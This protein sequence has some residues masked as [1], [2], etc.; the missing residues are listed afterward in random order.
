MSYSWAIYFLIITSTFHSI[1]SSYHSV[2][3]F[4]QVFY[5]SF[6][7]SSLM[8]PKLCFRLCD[9]P[10]IYLQKT[11]CRCSGG[12]LMHNKQNDTQCRI[13]CA[14]SAQFCGGSTTYSA[15]AEHGFYT[16][17]GHLLDYQIQY[18]SCEKWSENY[19]HNSFSVQLDNT[20]HKSSLNKLERCAAACLDQ[21]TTTKALAF[22]NDNNQCSCIK[23]QKWKMFHQTFEYLSSVPNTSCNRYCNNTFAHSDAQHQFQC[24]S[25]TDPSIWAIYDLRSACPSDFT[26]VTEIKKCMYI[27]KT[28]WFTCPPP[29][30]SYVYDGSIKWNIFLKVIEKL[31]LKNL[32]VVIEFH[33][34]FVINPSLKCQ[35]TSSSSSSISSAYSRHSYLNSYRWNVNNRYILENGCLREYI[36]SSFANRLCISE[37]IN[38]YSS[39]YDDGNSSIYISDMEPQTKYCPSSWFDLNG[40]CYRISEERKTI[41]D[42]RISCINISE[43]I[44]NTNDQS[45]LASYDEN[46]FDEDQL[47]NF[48]K[49][50]IVQYT[51]QWQT[52]LGFFLLDTL[53]ESEKKHNNLFLDP[54]NNKA[55]THVLGFY[56]E[57]LTPIEFNAHNSFINKNEFQMMN[58]I[59]NNNLSITDDSCII[60]TRTI[61]EEEE[62]PLLKN[63]PMNNCSQARHVLCETKTLIVRDFQQGCFRKPIILDLPALISN[64]LTYELCVSVCKEL[65]T[66]IA[67]I[68]INKCYCL[69]GYISKSFSLATDLRKYQQTSCGNPCS[70]NKNEQCG[71][72]DTIIVFHIIDSRR[73]YSD[74]RTPA[75]PYPDF[76]YDSCIYLNSFDNTSTTYKFKLTNRTDL[77]P[78]HCLELCTKYKQKYALINSNTCFCTN[79]QLKDEKSKSEIL[80][81]KH[82]SLQCSANYFY[83]CGHKLNSTLYSVYIMQP[84]CRHGFEVA[85]NDQQCVYSHL[86]TRKKSFSAAQSYCNS[87]G[88]KIAKINDALEIQDILPESILNTRLLKLFLM[89]T[90]L[91]SLNNTRYFWVDRTLDI[92]DNNT[93]S[94]RLLDKCSQT[95]DNIDGNCIVV[96]HE[97][98][99]TENETNYEFCVSESDQCSSISAMPVCVDQHIELN[100]T[101]TIDDNSFNISSDYSCGDNSDYHLV[102]DYCYKISIHEA[103]WNDSKLE[104]QRDNAMLFVP[105]KSITLQVIKTLFLF[106]HRNSYSSSGFAHVG[107]IYDNQNRTV[108]EY[109]TTNKNSLSFVPDSNLVYDLCEKTFHER[110]SILMSSNLSAYERNE[111][112][113]KQIGCA[114]IDLLSNVVPI[115]RCDEIPCNRTATVICQKLPTL[116]TDVIFVKREKIETQMK[117]DLI[118]L[119]TGQSPVSEYSSSVGRDFAPI[120]IVLALLSILTFVGCMT[121]FRNHRVFNNIRRRHNTD[122]V[123]TQL[124]SPNEF[125]LN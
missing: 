70:G 105:E 79:I 107:V 110:Y 112:K 21:D 113:N 48:P 86:S 3:C 90:R 32:S 87:I 30:K 124:A 28:S 58:P 18:S 84:K 6:F 29:S 77:H 62:K 27:Y 14:K 93:I 45:H 119:S 5:D 22:N 106:L 54:L 44:V 53:S 57:D 46:D 19:T 85:E 65:Q 61:A 9:T 41:Q 95:P 20:I 47:N 97:K 17:H 115:I 96:R 68:H 125:G 111:I 40:R 78:R 10:I 51:S 92:S 118:Y 108:I 56:Y 104:C 123:Y 24:G 55:I 67:I 50:D 52:R 80:A 12:G 15:Y 73:I 83:T 26:Y 69:N 13:K 101:S 33:E 89:I 31:K 117:N 74:A 121:K 59:E 1:H 71:N 7:T 60:S 76:I 120:F 16:R 37:S 39:S 42:A 102:D 99:T 36:Y 8:E 66:T 114:Y 82:C 25:L 100:T 98:K 63:L 81:N 34:D 2:G 11:V 103:S 88:G 94:N 43:N 64:R 38:K 116:K 4:T 23:T 91:K 49:G 75:E 122:S 35:N 72:K 109:N